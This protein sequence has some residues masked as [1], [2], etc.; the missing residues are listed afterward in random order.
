MLLNNT[1]YM[2]IIINENDNNDNDNNNNEDIEDIYVK[3][4]II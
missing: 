1:W 3:S 2:K 4:C